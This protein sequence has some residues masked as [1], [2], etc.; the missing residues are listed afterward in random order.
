ML[1]RTVLKRFVLT[2]NSPSIFLLFVI[3]VITSFGVFASFFGVA[4]CGDPK[5][6]LYIIH[7]ADYIFRLVF[8]AQ[9]GKPEIIDKFSCVL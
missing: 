7:S 8:R 5:S 2:M 6:F 9:G 1:V 4:T 3:L